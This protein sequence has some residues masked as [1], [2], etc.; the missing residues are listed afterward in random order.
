MR[1]LFYKVNLSE[2]SLR[3]QVNS[4]SYVLTGNSSHSL[5]I[6]DSVT[7]LAENAAIA[8]ASA[9]LIANAVDINSEKVCRQ[10]ASEMEMDSDLGE[11]L[12]TVDVM[13]WYPKTGQVVKL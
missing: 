10:P 6:A 2:V 5:G 9:T 8:D 12:I 11:Q 1:L 13:K 4:V 3:Y 7:V